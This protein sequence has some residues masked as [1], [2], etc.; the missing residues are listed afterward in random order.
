MES[1][2]L[3]DVM[4]LAYRSFFAFINNPLKK[5]TQETSAL[6]GFASHTLRLIQE[7]KPTYLGFV[8]DLP[9][10]TFRHEMY[11]E[12]KA[13]RKPMPDPLVSQLPLIDD[14]VAKSGLPMVS[15]EGFEADDLM[16]ALACE[17]RDLG[18]TT[19]IVTRDKDMMQLVDDKVFLFELGKAKLDSVVVGAAQVKEK[20][21]V[22][23]AQIVDYLSLIGDASDNVPGVAKVGPKTAVELLETYG[24]LE[25]IYENVENI[26]KKGLRENLKNDRENAFLSKKLVTLDCGMQVPIKVADLRYGGINAEATA[27]YL[28]EWDLKSL[29]RLVPGGATVAKAAALAAQ[30]AAEPTLANAPGLAG[31][32]MLAGAVA[33]ASM[34]LAGSVVQEPAPVEPEARYELIDTPEALEALAAT[35]AKAATIAVDTETTDLDNKVA[36]LVGLCLSIEAHAGFYVPVGHVEGR[37]LPL[38]AVAKALAPILAAPGKLLVFHNAKYDLPILR[39]SGL[40]AKD[41]GWPGK[42][43]RMADTLV[44]AHL[45]NPGERNLSLDDLALRHF[46]HSMIPIEALIGKGGRGAKQKNF[47]ETTIA[48]ACKYGAEDADITFRL[49]EVYERDLREKSLLDVYF[50][51]EI[52]L[53]PVL[54]SME[55]RGIT[56]DVETLNILSGR[57][58]EEIKRLEKEIHAAAGEEFNIGSPTQLQVILFEKLGLKAGK[59]TK[60]GYSTDAD[61][62]A[63]LE[64][65][66]EIVSKLLD[67][68]ESTKLQGTYVE[69]L[70]LLVHPATH[71]VHTNYSQVIAA[72]G[73]LSSINPNLQNIPIRTSLGREIRACFTASKPDR[74]LLCADYSQIELRLLAHLSG[75][76]AL[77]EAY[78]LGL[79]IHTRTAASLYKVPESEVTS[80][81]RRSAKVVNFGV[82]YG[83]GAQR[84][85]A[86][87]KIPRAEAARFIE[88]Y[89][90][91]FASVDQYITDTVDKGRKL[92]YVETLSGRRRYLPDLLSDNRMLKEN[93]E[94]IAANTPIQGS[95]ADLIKLAM[96]EIHRRLEGGGLDCEMLLQV[97]D[98]LVFEVSQKDADAAAA[99]IKEGMEGAM[100][101]EVPLVVGIGRAHDWLAA[102]S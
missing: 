33:Q 63:K 66:H 10:P 47:S 89:F 38:E 73:R 52:A 79:D 101:L 30:S 90:T 43:G 44:A 102:H 24:T 98:E 96:I 39:R 17:A 29:L 40:L 65:E 82:L 62:L 86:Q 53:L 70:P 94:R 15:L 45:S 100:K 84:L 54:E 22:P 6:F 3:I 13:H 18:I 23:P 31:A 69:A 88:N 14:F 75:D 97:H 95:A 5:G 11:K 51:E 99:L 49:W 25:R 92:G 37:N 93:A 26:P 8:R 35:L 12:Y 80:D 4:A 74:L 85:A 20:M 72:T 27:S 83:M 36:K 91:T 87:L 60:T 16:A 81:M 50:K 59:K 67:Y 9:K 48:E 21:G 34:D 7:C 64:G 56:L 57:L 46:A 61:V 1:L 77:R 28:T 78:R 32:A 19:Y 2:Y 55:A 71:R 41:F 76:P 68:R 42:P 58:D